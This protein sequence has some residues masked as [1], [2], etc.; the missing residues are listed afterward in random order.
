MHLRKILPTLDTEATFKPALN[1]LFRIKFTDERYRVCIMYLNNIFSIIICFVS[2][3][4]SHLII[5]IFIIYIIRTS[6]PS[7]AS[8]ESSKRQQYI[9]K[10]INYS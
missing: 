7:S 2:R 10:M 5:I 3:K 9:N 1:S 8:R 4:L 6:F